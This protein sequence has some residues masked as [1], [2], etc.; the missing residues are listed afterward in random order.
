MDIPDTT[1]LDAV[2]ERL[3][4]PG[5]VVLCGFPAS[6]KST[7][8]RYLSTRTG[9]PILDKDGFAPLLEESLMARLTGDPHD[10]DSDT[11]RALVAPGIYDGLIRTGLTVAAAGPVLLDAPFLSIIRAAHAAGRTLAAHFRAVGG[12]AATVP[13]RTIWL[14]TPADRIRERMRRRGAERDAPKLAGWAGYHDA[15]LESGTREKAHA[16][17]DLVLPS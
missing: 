6:G 13:V 11:Y 14:D 16:V 10:R 1:A 3:T 17:C 5:A 4:G 8:A 15:V 2:A 7:A 9:A 12:A